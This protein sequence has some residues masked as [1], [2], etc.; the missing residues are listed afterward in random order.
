MD[1]D[2][3]IRAWRFAERMRDGDP[4]IPVFDARLDAISRGPDTDNVRSWRDYRVRVSA[5][6]EYGA[7][8]PHHWADIVTFA[9]DEGCRI[10]VDN[11]AL[12]LT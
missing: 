3:A 5:G 2:T 11:N 7:V 4:D 12:V 10:T 9:I 1:E 6:R 8:E